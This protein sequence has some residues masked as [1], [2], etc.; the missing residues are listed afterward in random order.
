MTG[1]RALHTQRP[2]RVMVDSPH[3]GGGVG[4]ALRDTFRTLDDIPCDMVRLLDRL[5]ALV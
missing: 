5:R 1:D 2:R 4:D 3:P